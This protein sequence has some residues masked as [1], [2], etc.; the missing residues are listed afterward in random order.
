MCV[1]VPAATVGGLIGPLITSDSGGQP[2]TLPG[3]VILEFVCV[4]VCVCLCACVFV[5]HGDT[6]KNVILCVLCI[7]QRQRNVDVFNTLIEREKYIEMYVFVC[8]SVCVCVCVSS[9]RL[10]YTVT[11]TLESRLLPLWLCIY[12]FADK[13]SA[14]LLQVS[15][16]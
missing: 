7:L 11:Y 4:C 2:V 16:Y 1:K 13:Q 10:N 3:A 12:T 9:Q 8:V 14:C 5:A 6:Q 15:K